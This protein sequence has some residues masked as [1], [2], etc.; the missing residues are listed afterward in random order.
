MDPQDHL[1]VVAEGKGQA[2][3]ENPS[4]PKKQP[5]R[6]RTKRPL[7]TDRA[8][9][10]TQT[11]AL[12][13]YVQAS[14]RGERAVGAADIAQR[15]SITEATAALVNN[16]FVDAGLLTKER[17]GR[18]KP[19]PAVNEY[20]RLYSFKPDEAARQLAGPLRNSWYFTEVKADLQS[21]RVPEDVVMSILARAAGADWERKPQLE[22]VLDWLEAA[23]EPAAA[24]K[25]EQAEQEDPATDPEGG[26]GEGS[27]TEG[28]NAPSKA[29]QVVGFNFAFALTTEDLTKLKPEQI[30]AL[31]EAVGKVMAIKRDLP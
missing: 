20:H 18:Y 16:F 13:A 8:K 17:K 28:G 10:D 6:L 27:T 2:E 14:N 4:T 23:D 15:M 25:E 7:P 22:L 21:G 5:P 19:V 24:A 3:A 31:F 29:P 12:R 30:T 26:K 11:E 9:F 1:R